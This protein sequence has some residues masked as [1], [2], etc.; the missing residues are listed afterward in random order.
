MP[1][2]GDIATATLTVSPFDGT[3]SATLAVTAPDGTESTPSTSTADSGATWTAAVSY[4]LPGWW[5]LSW[6]VTGTGAGV[7]HQ[8]VWVT[9]TPPTPP[10][11]PV[12]TTLGLVKESLISGGV[13]KDARDTLLVEKIVSASRSIDQ[14]CG[15][16]FYLDSTATARVIDPAGRTRRDR[17]GYHLLIDDI[18]T[19]TGLVVE[20]GSPSAG[21]SAVTG[22][23]EVE[24]PDAAAKVRPFT[25]L[26]RA[27]N[28]LSVRRVRITA[29]WGWP[30]VP[31]TIREATLIQALR[32][33]KRKDSPEGV[34]GSAEWGTVR[35]SRLDPDVAALVS[36]FERDGFA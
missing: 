24:P 5:L 19:D 32:L 21:W 30:E 9:D 20:V 7:E 12:Y 31:Q 3:T 11:G 22:L 35:V 2:V 10:H 23:V 28:W 6:T 1:D 15:R 33:Y 27:A 25:A 29:R 18:G 4:T 8:K 34:L 36:A 26:R 14:H 17:D 16:R 13:L